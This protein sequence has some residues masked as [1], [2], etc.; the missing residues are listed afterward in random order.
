MTSSFK[1][2]SHS[3]HVTHS[4]VSFNHSGVNAFSFFL[5]LLFSLFDFDRK[6]ILKIKM[7]ALLSHFPP[8]L[9][10]IKREIFIIEILIESQRVKIAF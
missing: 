1:A 6:E 2:V 10:L 3:K 7:D 9:L 5:L 4:H 8:L